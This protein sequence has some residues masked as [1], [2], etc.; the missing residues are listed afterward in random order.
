MSMNK[1]RRRDEIRV[2]PQYEKRCVGILAR[3]LFIEHRIGDSSRNSREL[4][5]ASASI[6]D[7]E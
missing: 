4:S 6:D 1:G 5:N 2:T 3:M 7:T